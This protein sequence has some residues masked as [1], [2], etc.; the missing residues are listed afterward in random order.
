VV[1]GAVSQLLCETAGQ[2]SDPSFRCNEDSAGDDR[3]IVALTV[4]RGEGDETSIEMVAS[5]VFCSCSLLCS[6]FD[7]AI[8]VQINHQHPL[9]S[10]F[11]QTINIKTCKYCQ[12]QQQHGNAVHLTDTRLNLNEAIDRRKERLG[13]VYFG[14][15]QKGSK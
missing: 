1:Q 3:I 7:H 10:G 15:A 8:L 11:C 5:S 9:G 14:T 4:I 13:V 2:S 12:F 6:F